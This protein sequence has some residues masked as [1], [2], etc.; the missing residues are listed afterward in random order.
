MA[1]KHK[2]I[3]IKIAEN[4]RSTA[5][6]VNKLDDLVLTCVIDDDSLLDSQI[7]NLYL[8][9]A[10]KKLIQIDG[11]EKKSNKLIFD[12]KNGAFDVAG[13]YLGQLEFVDEDGRVTSNTFCFEVKDI[14]FTSDIIIEDVG[15]DIFTKMQLELEYLK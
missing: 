3:F 10:D 5:F 14:L 11:Y 8:L 1:K 9:K 13:G 2:E 6:S 4:T 7:I 12:I 15:T